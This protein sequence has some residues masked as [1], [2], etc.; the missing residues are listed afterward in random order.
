MIWWIANIQESFNKDGYFYVIV[1]SED[2]IY[3]QSTQYATV[4]LCKEAVYSLQ[5]SIKKYKDK[6]IKITLYV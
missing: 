3:F 2:K 1:G 5:N 6:Y 4:N